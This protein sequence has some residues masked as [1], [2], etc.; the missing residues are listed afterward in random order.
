MGAPA[1]FCALTVTGEPPSISYRERRSLDHVNLSESEL[2]HLW[3]RA[4]WHL[5]TSQIAPTFLLIVTIGLLA[6]GL[7]HSSVAVRLATLGILFSSGIL[8]AVAQLSASGEATAVT[9]DLA[10]LPTRSIISDRIIGY[11]VWVNVV[12]FV[13]PT[14]FVLTFVALIV[15]LFVH[16]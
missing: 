7:S 15:A 8:G 12:R 13:T 11:R 5:I 2:I 1:A 10:A 6:D 3:Q 14:I 4:R 16:S 9:R